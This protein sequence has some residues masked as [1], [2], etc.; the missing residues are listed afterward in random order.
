MRGLTEDQRE[1]LEDLLYQ[2]VRLRTEADLGAPPPVETAA[3]WKRL[4]KYKTLPEWLNP[5]LLIDVEGFVHPRYQLEMLVEASTALSYLADYVPRIRLSFY[6]KPKTKQGMNVW[7][8][9]K[10]L[11]AKERMLTGD[12]FW[13]DIDLSLVAW[14]LLDPMGRIR[15]LHH[16]ASHLAVELDDGAHPTPGLRGHTAEIM[17]GTLAEVGPLHHGETV[18]GALAARRQEVRKAVGSTRFLDR[19][20][21]AG[22]DLRPLDV[23]ATDGGV[24]AIQ[25]EQPSLFDDAAPER[26]ESIRDINNRLHGN[27]RLDRVASDTARDFHKSMKDMGVESMTVTGP[28]G[29]V[30]DYTQEGHPLVSKGDEE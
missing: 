6:R 9:A 22:L 10:K 25:G 18:V 29:H 24:V 16:E 1:Q 11:N 28:D 7:G 26:G 2:G 27:T 17:A 12:A 30:T 20:A 15:L 23:M 3:A 19:L 8:Q 14:A 5:D 4:S 21:G 13:W